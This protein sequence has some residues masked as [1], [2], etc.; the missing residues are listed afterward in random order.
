MNGGLAIPAATYRLQLGPGLAFDEATALAGY[1][2][3]LGASHAYLS[4]V[5]E[6]VPGS[7]HGYDVVRHDAVSAAL[8]GEAGL[9]RLAARLADAG[10]GLVVDFVPNHMGVDQPAANPWW[11]DVL[12]NGNCSPYTAYFDVDWDPVK[13][14][15]RGRILLPV[16]GDQYG[17]VLERGELALAF[18]DGAFVLRYWERTLPVNPRRAPLVLRHGLEALEAELGPAD[19]DLRELLSV[20]TALGN[21]PTRFERDAARVIER[22]RE[23]EI[24]RERLARL[25]ERS[26]RIRRHVEDAVREFN[27]RAGDPASFDALHGLLESQVY[28]LAYWRTAVHEINYRRFF[29]V[30]GLASVRME[31]PQVFDAAHVAIVRLVAAGR[32]H[33]LRLDHVDG[34]A[35]PGQYLERLGAAVLAARGLAPAGPGGAPA[36]PAH[37]APAPDG[38][39]RARALPLWVVGEKV[40]SG[41]ERLPGDWAFHGTTGYDFLND[42]TG[43]FV[44][45][46]GAAP[47]R[48]LYQRFTRRWP[49]FSDVAWAS[50]RLVMVSTL[51]GELN[52]LAH[53]LNRISE[54]DRHS[55]DFTLNSLHDMLLQVVACFPVYRTYA[56]AAGHRDED[57]RILER[58]VAD[59]RRRNPSL[60]ASIFEFFLDVMLDRTRPGVDDD[61]RAERR[62]FARKFQQ[63]TG[64]VQAK[65]VE[66]TAFYRYVPLLALNE[67]GGDPLR[68]GRAPEAFHAANR[69]RLA[70]WPYAMTATAT[71]DTKRGEDARLRLAVLSEVPAAWRAA[72]QRW[73]RINAA[74]RTRVDGDW[75]PDRGDEYFFYQALIGA[76][77]AGP[78][79]PAT[80]CERMIAYM[81]KATRESKLHT[82]WISEHQAYEQATRAFVEGA[83]VGR[84]SGAFL[85]A[86]EPFAR[87]IAALGVVNSLAAVTLKVAAP[88]VPDFYQGTELWDLN[89]VD[90]DNRRPVDF[91]ARRAM[92]EGLEPLLRAAAEGTAAAGEIAALLAAPADGRVKLHVTAAALRLRRARPELF[93][94]GDYLPLEVA[95]RHASRIVAFARRRGDEAAIVVAPRLVAALRD[96][97]PPPAAAWEDTRVLTAPLAPGGWRDVIGGAAHAAAGDPASLAVP[98]LFA[99]LPVALLERR[100]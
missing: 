55:R 50:K 4:P 34:L 98:A 85:E 60:E 87:R 82:S 86:F 77:P 70:R 84:R 83:L 6:A 7:D 79:D 3:A 68:F 96:E 67:V 21:L 65:G 38:P 61:M 56:T 2:A 44:D 29:D 45:P 75:A 41:P 15:L 54:R 30:N 49:D 22:Q 12:E 88:G 24:A 53:A 17:A 27:G 37:A 90:P 25:V 5:L 48:R 95:G 94:D 18:E 63:Y 26:P 51:A 99:R 64:P 71:H 19:P 80:L 8:G 10:L 59:A 72:V 31:D 13:P 73:A 20:A 43:L 97:G 16:L 58:A 14:E 89:L 74:N 35:D 33:G 69:E 46:A 91:A 9:E 92:L 81:R 28:R 36:S 57:R 40:L 39:A 78:A 76:W 23:K 52:L 62:E 93:L 100:G 32:V 42:L 47:F 1:L 66:D 11:W